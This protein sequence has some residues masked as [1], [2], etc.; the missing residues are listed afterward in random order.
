MNNLYNI[1]SRIFVLILIIVIIFFT[2]SN[3]YSSKNIDKL[4]YVVA[5]G[6]DVGTNND[7]KLSIQLAKPSASSSSSSSQ[8]SSSVVNSV[9]C[10]SIEAG[11]N[12]FNSYISRTINLSHCKIIVI[13]EKL[14]SRGISEYLYDLSNNVEVSSHAN[15]IITKC[16]ANTFLKMTNP[17]LENFPARYYEIVN[18]SA[19][20]TGYT[21]ANSLTDF[22]SEYLDT[23]KE[24]TAVLSNINTDSTHVELASSS[25]T[26][27]D[28]SYT[29]GETPITSSNNIENMGIAVF[30]SR[31]TCWRI[32]WNR[33]NLSFNDNRRIKVL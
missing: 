10:S 25:F 20:I 30:R 16:E 18:T 9:D 2:L 32:K 11:I 19:S 17:T 24:P 5:L 21:K 26:N 27:K 4:A 33:I 8:S 31:K 12:L 3:S 29:A 14:A 1:I 13:S 7:I 23:C 15:I 28:S 6:I 22:F